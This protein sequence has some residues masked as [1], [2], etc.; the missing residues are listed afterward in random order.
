[1]NRFVPLLLTLSA[2]AT[3]SSPPPRVDVA[4]SRCGD[5][6]EAVASATHPD[7]AVQAASGYLSCVA[8]WESS[9]PPNMQA[10]LSSA[11][12]R[13]VYPQTRREAADI[14]ARFFDAS[15]LTELPDNR[16]DLAE[17]REVLDAQILRAQAERDTKFVAAAEKRAQSLRVLAQVLDS[18]NEP[19]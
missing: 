5:S 9:P 2:C 19:E 13:N 11:L 18:M 7:A 14:L 17:Y 10:E 16:R 12:Q 1:M 3:F 6:L 8:T 15:L 4:P